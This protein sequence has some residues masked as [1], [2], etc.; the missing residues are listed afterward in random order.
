MINKPP[1][2]SKKLNKL[3]PPF[4]YQ[5]L[6]PR[7]IR[8]FQLLPGDFNS[9]IA[10]K[11]YEC[12]LGKAKFAY[13]ALSY[14][15]G[16][17]TRKISI[18]CNGAELFITKN[19]QIALR[20]IRFLQKPRTLWVDA[21]CINQDD[22][23]EREQQVPYMREIYPKADKV[24]V[25]LGEADEKAELALKAIDEWA[26]F[27]R[28]YHHSNDATRF[29]KFE[30]RFASKQDYRKLEELSTFKPDY[31]DTLKAVGELT[32]RAWFN[33]CWTFQEILLSTKAILLVGESGL[34]WEQFY[35]ALEVFPL[36]LLAD[37]V[38]NFNALVMCHGK[39]KIGNNG[40]FSSDSIPVSRNLSRLLQITRNFTASDPRDK[41]YSLLSVA[42]VKNPDK[43]L[44]N[45][46]VS[47]RK[48][49]IYLTLDM[50]RDE[51][52]LNVLMS[53]GELDR[54]KNLPSWCPDLRCKRGVV[55]TG[56]YDYISYNVNSGLRTDLRN[57]RTNER[58]ELELEGALIDVVTE[59]FDLEE[60]A[61]ELKASL[62]DINFTAVLSEF[63]R[64]ISLDRLELDKDMSPE[65]SL[66]R[67][68]SADHW[69]F[70][71]YLKN[72]YREQWFPTHLRFRDLKRNIG[73]SDRSVGPTVKMEGY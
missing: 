49:F 60:L 28:Q 17:P 34:T 43:F 54:D 30:E 6:T 13:E 21:I 70:G 67:T 68:L 33:R 66:L 51:S 56:Y 23:F 26:N 20:R 73:P 16:D 15:W 7:H 3:I 52:S 69:F 25:W 62:I 63:S 11:L 55:L 39:A 38:L 64:K 36:H 53:N 58:F 46:S 22:L 47:I 35:H 59:V 18:E 2:N 4:I 61:Q 14:V 10:I 37:D 65:A 9:S 31:R 48:T 12:D 41:I 57:L 42:Q 19:L 1:K 40:L 32:Y 72:S 71:S 44:P 50:I 8:L 29:A 45:Y 24:L 27:N 5:P